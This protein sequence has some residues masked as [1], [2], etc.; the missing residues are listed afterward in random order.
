MLWNV[1]AV[2]LFAFRRRF[3]GGGIP[4]P[5]RAAMNAA[6]LSDDAYGES[7]VMAS[8]LGDDVDLDDPGAIAAALAGYFP[9][10]RI[11]ALFDRVVAKACALRRPHPPLEGEGRRPRAPEKCEAVFGSAHAQ[12]AAGWGEFA[13]ERI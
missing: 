12:I 9:A 2:R 7:V 10:A 11:D 3:V 8:W 6:A 5:W 13:K 4:H 1:H